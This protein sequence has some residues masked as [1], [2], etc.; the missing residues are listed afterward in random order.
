[1]HSVTA[2]TCGVHLQPGLPLQ[3]CGNL[4]QEL[5][6]HWHGKI[7]PRSSVAKKKDSEAGSLRACGEGAGVG[8]RKGVGCHWA[9]RVVEERDSGQRGS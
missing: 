2:Q 5:Q 9:E 3:G 1:M 4:S 7:V 8:G 6:R